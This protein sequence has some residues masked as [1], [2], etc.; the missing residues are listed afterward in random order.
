MKIYILSLLKS[1]YR[2]VKNSVFDQ[3]ATL[4]YSQEGEDMILNRIFENKGNSK[5]FYIDIGAHHPKRFSN[6]YYFYR[7]G[8]TGINVEPNPEVS[9]L[10]KSKRSRDINLQL[11]VSDSSGSLQ[12]YYFNDP[13]LN[14]FSLDIVKDRLENTAYKLV[15]QQQIKIMR[16]DEILLKYLP[17]NIVVIDFLTID[18]EGFDLNVLKSNDWSRFRPTCVL[19]EILNSTFEGI[20]NSEIY[21]FMKSK[22]YSLI[23]RTYN[24]VIFKID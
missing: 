2:N 14:T 21:N 1:V 18:V 7:R 20:I 11:G 16:L 23:A 10:F 17:D 9:A 13:A 4:S 5:G 8:W 15:K 24:T 6:T 22:G 3:F 19:V 12:Y